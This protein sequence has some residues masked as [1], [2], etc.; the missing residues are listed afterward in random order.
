[1]QW[2]ATVQDLFHLPAQSGLSATFTPDPQLGRF[3]NN[4][5]RLGMSAGLWRDYQR[6][7]ETLAEQVVADPTLF[8]Q[9][10][11]EP[12][13]LGPRAFVASFGLRAFRRPLKDAELDHY[14]QLFADAPAAFPNSDAVTAGTRMVV[15]AML[16]SPFFLYRSELSTVVKGGGIPLDG[17]EIAS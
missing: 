8:A 1:A 9:L 14:A 13:N 11:P 16:Q 2:E 6:A 15:Q 5:A 3:D 7:A 10:V 12:A 17:Y 4:I